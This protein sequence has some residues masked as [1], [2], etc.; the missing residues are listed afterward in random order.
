MT[1]LWI[2]GTFGSPPNYDP[3]KFHI[4]TGIVNTTHYFWNVTLEI[5]CLVTNVHFSQIIFNSDDVQSS[6]QY[7][8]VYET[9][10]NDMYGGFLE[11]P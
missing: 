9:W 11:V 6:N 3:I 5:M 10:I 8:I 7:F 2:R 1:S 4:Y